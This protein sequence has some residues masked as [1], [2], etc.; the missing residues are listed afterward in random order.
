MKTFE[1]GLI[2]LRVEAKEVQYCEENA[3]RFTLN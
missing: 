2:L 3:V 1:I